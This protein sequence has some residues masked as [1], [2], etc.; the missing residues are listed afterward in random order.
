[1]ASWVKQSV[2]KR[3]VSDKER[4]MCGWTR[5]GQGKRREKDFRVREEGRNVRQ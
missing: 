3:R 1:M 4:G 2:G 5:G